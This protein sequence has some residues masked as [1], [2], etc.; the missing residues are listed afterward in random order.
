MNLLDAEDNPVASPGP[1]GDGAIK[2]NVYF[3][4]VINIGSVAEVHIYYF[5]LEFNDT[6]VSNNLYS[7]RAIK[8]SCSLDYFTDN[9]KKTMSTISIPPPQV[10]SLR[11]LS[12]RLLQSSRG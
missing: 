9:G 11:Y 7:F 1:D 12:V 10:R 5:Y 6:D 4:L 2:F 3:P 8:K